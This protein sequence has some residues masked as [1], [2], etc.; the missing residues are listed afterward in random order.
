MNRSFFRKSWLSVIAFLILAAQITGCS[1]GGETTAGVG[2]GGTGSLAKTVSGTVADGYLEN[3]MVFL[4]KHGNYQWDGIEPHT[5]TDQNGGYQLKIDPADVG[6][7]PIVALAIKDTTKDTGMF[8]TNSYVLS[9][10]KEIVSD[11]NGNNFISPITS[12]LHEL[13]ETNTYSSWQQAA[14]ALAANLGMPDADVTVDYLAT[15]NTAM[16]TAAQT[17]ATL[18]GS[19]MDQVL[20]GSGESIAVDVNRYRGMMG[21][22]FSN[23][24]SVS[25]ANAQTGM[26][27]LKSTMTTV[28]SST[29]Q[30]VT[31]QPYHNMSTAFR[32][33]MGGVN[34][35]PGRM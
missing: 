31:G 18:M 12:Q 21:T 3:A 24:A 15:G 6:K 17:M 16:H 4:D 32:G 8:I 23:M 28:L 33:V 34:T 7:F 13:M 22:I 10:P 29:P 14:S 20:S 35:M 2:T 11:A 1:S 25:G 27:T 9:M 30:T 26:D 19:Q 5:T